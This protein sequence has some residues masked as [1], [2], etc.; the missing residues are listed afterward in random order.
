[1]DFFWEKI[2]V[3]AIKRY[4][5]PFYL[6]ACEPVRQAFEKLKTLETNII[7]KNWYSFKTHPIRPLVRF[8]QSHDYG[9]EVVSEFEF[10]AALEEGY[11]PESILINGVAKHEW[12]KKYKIR[13]LR[14]HFDSLTE[15]NQ[16]ISYAREYDWI[17]GL[18]CH[19][20][21]EYDPDEPTFSGQFGLSANEMTEAVSV[22][23]NNQLRLEGFHFHLRTNVRAAPDY[24]RAIDEVAKLCIN[25]NFA[26]KYIDCGGGL[27][28]TGEWPINKVEAKKVFNFIEFKS[29]LSGIANKFPSIEEIW[30]ENGRF[31][32]AQSCVLIIKILD[33]KQRSECRYLICDG[34]RTNQ[35]LVSDWETHQISTYPNKGGEMCLT[36]ICGPTC[37]A[38]DR[39]ARIPM[40]K[41]IN[42]GDYIVWHNAGA[43][44]IPWETRFS[45]GLAKVVW[46]DEDSRLSLV[47]DNESFQDWWQKW[48]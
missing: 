4:E 3:Q 12:L 47:R 33:I 24:G 41:D 7:F 43:Y 15:I 38:Y 20:S 31:I 30:M 8:L 42:I 36:T 46:F 28:V 44:H 26:P 2:I 29:I 13:G 27:P 23:L 40:S 1:M 5:T 17:I 16:L 35:A 34:G 6:S 10:L 45:H 18:R 22:L 14:V 21:E 39:L 37:M 9:I 11:K 25:L 32:S 19:V 48:I